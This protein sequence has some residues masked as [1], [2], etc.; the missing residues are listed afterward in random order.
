MGRAKLWGSTRNYTSHYNFLNHLLLKQKI[1]TSSQNQNNYFKNGYGKMT[2]REVR[3]PHFTQSGDNLTLANCA[4][5]Y[6]F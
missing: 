4:K 5:S 3:F 1:I 2:L 6:I